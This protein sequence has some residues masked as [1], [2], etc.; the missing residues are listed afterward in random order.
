MVSPRAGTAILS[1]MDGRSGGSVFWGPACCDSLHPSD[2]ITNVT[3]TGQARKLDM[4]ECSK[5][6]NEESGFN[7]KKEREREMLLAAAKKVGK[8]GKWE[9]VRH[10]HR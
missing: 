10:R 9:G 1:A 8:G 5:L 3:V 2:W 4:I 6:A 7:F